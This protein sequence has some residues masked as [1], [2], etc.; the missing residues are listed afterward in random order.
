MGKST[1]C[2]GFFY[3]FGAIKREV[4]AS[5]GSQL[6]FRSAADFF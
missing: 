3:T 5:G 4:R 2:G 1:F 6:W